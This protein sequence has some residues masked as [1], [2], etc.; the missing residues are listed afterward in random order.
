[1]LPLK[2]LRHFQK[3]CAAAAAVSFTVSDADVSVWN[4]TTAAWQVVHGDYAISVGSS[5]ADIRL[6]GKITV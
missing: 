1:M 2:T 6:T 4:T 5:S 3:V